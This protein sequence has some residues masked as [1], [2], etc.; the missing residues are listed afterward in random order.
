MAKNGKKN[1]RKKHKG[2][3]GKN[4]KRAQAVAGARL[5]LE[6]DR[7]GARRRRPPRS[8]G[9]EPLADPS[10]VPW[11]IESAGPTRL[12]QFPRLSRRLLDK[13]IDRLVALA[14]GGA[15]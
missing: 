6:A 12:L 14:S 13:E 1:A 5:A 3:N 11:S 9:H 8:R 7:H 4:G 10:I 15:R 2:K